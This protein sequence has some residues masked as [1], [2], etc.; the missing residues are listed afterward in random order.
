[1]LF[2][3]K[4]N[5][6]CI[7]FLRLNRDVV[8]IRTIIIIKCC[9]TNW[10]YAA[11]SQADYVPFLNSIAELLSTCQLNTWCQAVFK[12][13]CQIFISASRTGLDFYLKD[14]TG[15]SEPNSRMPRALN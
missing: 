1:M 5:R 7:A 15:K 3:N 13:H 4:C 10:S 2:S 9:H 8:Q 11:G 14:K 12:V 6:L